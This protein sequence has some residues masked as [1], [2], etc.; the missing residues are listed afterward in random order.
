MRVAG[1]EPSCRSPPDDATVVPARAQA[2]TLFVSLND[3]P[4]CTPMLPGSL[5]PS[6]GTEVDLVYLDAFGRA[7]AASG[8]VRLTN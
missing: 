3:L 6:V 5:V 2:G 1:R 4:R 7:S 8:R